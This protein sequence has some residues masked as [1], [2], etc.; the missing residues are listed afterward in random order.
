[1]PPTLQK[2]YSGDLSWGFWNFVDS[3][4]GETH[5]RLYGLACDLQNLE[6]KVLRAC[7]EAG[8]TIQP[9]ETDK[10]RDDLERSEELFAFLQGTV[11][12]GH[13]LDAADVPKLTPAQ[14]WCVIWY[15]GEQHWRVPDYIERCCRCG[16][17]YDTRNEGDCLDEGAPPHHF[18]EGCICSDEYEAKLQQ[19]EEN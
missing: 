1:M 8:A 7:A 11:P 5:D 9:P 6:S 14:A 4:E 10:E 16:S 2:R 12:D 3:L 17:L 13:F 18:C 19:T 15:L